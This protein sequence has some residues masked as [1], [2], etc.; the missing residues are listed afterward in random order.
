ML[1][2]AEVAHWTE[3]QMNLVLETPALVCRNFHCKMRCLLDNSAG[4]LTMQVNGNLK[5]LPVRMGKGAAQLALFAIVT[6][7]K[8]PAII[9][10]Y[11]RNALFCSKHKLDSTPLDI[12]TKGRYVLGWTAEEL[13]R[14]SGYYY[15][16]TGDLFHCAEYHIKLIRTGES[17][18]TVFRLLHKNQQWVWVRATARLVY[19][20]G[21]PDCIIAKQQLLTNAEGEQHLAERACSFNNDGRTDVLYDTSIRLHR[22]TKPHLHDTNGGFQASHSQAHANLNRGIFACYEEMNDPLG[23]QKETPKPEGY[24]KED[25]GFLG[26][27]GIH[28]MLWRYDLSQEDIECSWKDLDNASAVGRR[29]MINSCCPATEHVSTGPPCLVEALLVETG[30]INRTVEGHRHLNNALR[31]RLHSGFR[32]YPSCRARAT[33]EWYGNGPQGSLMTSYVTRGE[34]RF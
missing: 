19:K 24:G 34:I 8:V 25:C 29:D 9:E 17:G 13:R 32:H 26:S 7:F 16:H 6:P 11:P 2:C 5:L 18:W 14:N 21:Q 22:L 12:D 3:E 33:V 4:F 31:G 20:N 23:Y 10:L 27:E 1:G 15:V 30:R 28:E